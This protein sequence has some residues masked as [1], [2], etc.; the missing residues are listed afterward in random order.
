MKKFILGLLIGGIL[1]SGGWFAWGAIQSQTGIN[2]YAPVPASGSTTNIWWPVKDISQFV[3]ANNI[4]TGVIPAAPV[5]HAPGG[6][7][8]QRCATTSNSTASFSEANAQYPVVA[9]AISGCG[10]GGCGAID[11]V[12]TNTD[13]DFT[14]SGSNFALATFSITSAYDAATGFILKMRGDATNG[15]FVQ[16]KSTPFGTRSDTFT[17]AANGTAVTRTTSPLRLFSIQATGT[18]TQVGTTTWDVR[19]ECSLN[20]TTY[21]TVL[22][23]AY[24]ATA[25]GATVSS[26]TLNV[27]CLYMRSRLEAITLGTATNV[28]VV[29]LGMV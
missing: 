4:S 9:A 1:L 15:L 18:G 25:D 6:G 8:Y 29:I 22:T 21:T 10:G 24:P 12:T 11:S 19:L 13:T 20:G 14:P 16:N 17:V 27:P 5:C 26:G 2:V 28:V 23:H 3:D 7:D